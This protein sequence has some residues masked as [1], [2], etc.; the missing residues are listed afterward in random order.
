MTKH[1]KAS[2]L[3]VPIALVLANIGF[4]FIF[5]IS[6][7]GGLLSLVYFTIAV[8]LPGYICALLFFRFFSM[9]SNELPSWQFILPLLTIFGLAGVLISFF[10]GHALNSSVLFYAFSLIYL[11]LLITPFRTFFISSVRRNFKIG[12]TLAE[13]RV[14]T[15]LLYI[16]SIN[17][18]FFLSR[19]T[20][21]ILPLD[22]FH[23]HI[24]NVGNTVSMMSGFPLK[25]M[26]IETQPYLSYHVLVHILGSHMA[27]ITGLIP[28]M[29]GLQFVFIPLVP[30]L[31]LNMV[32][33]FGRF[34]DRKTNYLF[35]GL[36]VLLF[37]GGFS[38]VHEV[39]V[40]SLLNSN[41]N[42]MG[43]ILLFPVVA[44]MLDSERYKKTGSLLM[45][46]I[47]L[48]LV[49]A[50]KGSIGASLIIG[51]MSWAFFRL[52][53]KRIN[54]K[55]IIDSAGAL[56]G[57]VCSYVL[58]FRFPT[59]YQPILDKAIGS[60]EHVIAAP[61]AYVTKNALARPFMD[62]IQNHIPEPYQIVSLI[63]LTISLLSL[64]LVLYFSY[65]LLVIYYIKKIG[66]E[67]RNQK[68][69]FVI[70]GSLFITFMVNK[71]P[72]DHA[73]LITSALFMLDV[74]FISYLQKEKIFSLLRDFF[75]N[76]NIYGAIGILVI[77]ILP[78]L[79]TTGW[80]RKEY[81]YNFFM[82]GKIGQYM[83]PSFSRT[84]YR[85]NHQSI[86]PKFYDALQYIRKSSEKN[87]VVIAPFVKL[88]DGRSLAFYTSAFAERPAYLEGNDFGGIRKYIG[89]AEIERRLETIKD[90]YENY[91][92]PSELM[93][94]KYY[95]LVN[96]DTRKGL[97]TNHPTKVLYDNNEWCVLQFL[98]E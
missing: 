11:T 89:S 94:T 93:N 82:Y 33:F 62:V 83:D 63:G 96:E 66:I 64:Y 75:K 16:L 7:E 78:F 76:G 29:V 32:N 67:E 37:G 58:F 49:T 45:L 54:F 40:N 23:D 41:T 2:V 8:L 18:L 56:L 86:T 10:M 42:F 77:I 90:I 19:P 98:Q 70:L 31:I 30:L 71:D 47:G 1:I 24:W 13:W 73:Y 21:G 34:L 80:A 57:F 88:K 74:L 84:E 28:H 36:A 92:V 44:L 91:R 12:S 72:Q 60:G 85:Q 50:A 39:K 14:P 51:M 38:I 22:I 17:V 69:L 55:D 48:F 3:L 43:V 95:Y 9:G 52:W 59:L 25:S 6:L 87:A 46:F 68:V 15:I 20:P 79:S 81:A 26:N 35:Y 53:K 27:R 4:F 61:L 97:E 65:R 5:S